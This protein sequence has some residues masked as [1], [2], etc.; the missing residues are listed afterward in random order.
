MIVVKPD[1]DKLSQLRKATDPEM[2]QVDPEERKKEISQALSSSSA[3]DIY[4]C[5][6]FVCESRNTARQ[7]TY[8]L[9]TAFEI[10]SSKVTKNK[11]IT[12][13]KPTKLVI[14]LREPREI[15]AEMKSNKEDD[16]EAWQK[17]GT[18]FDG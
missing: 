16:S 9:A 14:D 1:S 18:V 12:K 7:L 15:E 6:A 17:L 4:R 11:S 10:F 2:Q 3:P 5:H 13:R 8:T